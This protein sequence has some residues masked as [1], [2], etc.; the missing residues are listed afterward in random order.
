ADRLEK[1]SE[2]VKMSNNAYGEDPS[3]YVITRALANFERSLIS[4]HSKYDEVIKGNTRFSDQEEIGYN[5]FKS[6]RLACTSCH[7]G[8]NFTDYSF[9]NNGLYD[10]YN[11][12][13]RYRLTGKEDDKAMFKTPS[14]RNVALTAPYMHDGSLGDLESVVE[15]YMSGGS[16]H[17]HKSEHLKGFQLSGLEKE[18]LIAFLKTLTDFQF[19]NNENFRNE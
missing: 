18:A 1:D 5:L 10:V 4:G 2:Y 9:Q 15:H 7:S 3:P 11:D 16:K 12:D 6:E 13:G 17:Q 19:I 8:F 14:L